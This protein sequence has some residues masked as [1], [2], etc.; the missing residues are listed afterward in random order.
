V[1]K[2]VWVR[3][4]PFGDG[5]ATPG[6]VYEPELG[7]SLDAMLAAGDVAAIP[8]VALSAEEREAMA[9]KAEET[10]AA[11]R[12]G[13]DPTHVEQERQAGNA[14][15]VTTNPPVPDVEEA[16]AGVQDADHAGTGAPTRGE[17]PA[18]AEARKAQQEAAAEPPRPLTAD[19]QVGQGIVPATQ[20]GE[21]VEQAREIAPQDVQRAEDAGPVTPEQ[22]EADKATSARRDAAKPQAPAP[23][24]APADKPAAKGGKAKGGKA[25]G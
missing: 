1:P 6:E 12:A 9:K 3:S 19:E 2:Y 5:R 10:E 21:Q 7:R 17:L 4:V 13:T 16:A 20:P 23:V 24:A 18:L 15:I 14:G 25:K 11:R 22:V 8:D